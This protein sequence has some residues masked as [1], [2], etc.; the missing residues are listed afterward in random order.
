M[1]SRRA[2]YLLAL[3]ATVAVVALAVDLGRG[4]PQPDRALQPV[5]I[6]RGPR[7]Q[8]PAGPARRCLRGGLDGR[9]RVHVEL[10]ADRRAVVIPAGIGIAGVRERVYGRITAARCHD[11]AWTVDPTGVVHL[12][13]AGMTLGD[14][15]AVWGQPLA[16]DRLAGFDGARV[17][18][19]VNGERRDG[20]P[21]QLELRDRDQIVLEIGGYVPPHRTYVFPPH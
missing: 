17:A 8:P 18:L 1:P 9:L 21:T 3:A 12:H 14:V 10:F 4:D 20:S 15:F 16:A 11:R 7:Y 2:A 6:G 19:F 13:A 5:P